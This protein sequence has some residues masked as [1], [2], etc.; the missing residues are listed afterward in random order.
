MVTHL[1]LQILDLRLVLFL[2]LVTDNTVHLIHIIVR[3]R[4]L[5]GDRVDAQF[6]VGVPPLLDATDHG[7]SEEMRGSRRM[8]VNLGSRGNGIRGAPPHQGIHKDA[9][10]DMV[11]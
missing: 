11:A 3:K 1:N 9:P 10:S 2:G 8:G 6:T 5:G 4:G 7:D